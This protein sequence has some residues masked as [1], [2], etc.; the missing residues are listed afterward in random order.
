MVGVV[1]NAI[2]C[3]FGD[4]DPFELKILGMVDFYQYF[5]FRGSNG[6]FVSFIVSRTSSLNY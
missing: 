1:L 2:R 6:N 5:E 4:F 3:V